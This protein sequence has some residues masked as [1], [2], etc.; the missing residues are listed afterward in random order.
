MLEVVITFIAGIV[1]FISP[2]VLPLVPAY[3]GYMGGRVTNTVS[4][5]ISV[6]GDGTAVAQPTHARFNT[7]LHGIAFVA[8]FTFIF[9]LLGVM[10]TAVLGQLGGQGTVIGIIGRLG[11]IVI[12]FF[13]FHFMGFVPKIFNWFRNQPDIINNPAFTILVALLLT[14]IFVWGFTGT[15]TP[16]MESVPAIPDWTIAVGLLL[17]VIT[18]MGMVAGGGFTEPQSFWNKAMNTVE[19]SIYADTRKDMTAS[20]NQGFG[21]SALMGVVFAAGWTP[22]IGPTLGAALTLAASNG[23]EVARGGLLLGA[24]SL[25]L[26][27]PFLLTAL[28]L[29]SAQGI[30]RR[31][32]RHMGIIELVSGAFLIFIGILVA[33]G[34][35]QTL[36]QRFA[37]EFAD[38]SYRIEECV[39]GFFEGDVHLNQVGGCL[40][41]SQSLESIRELNTGAEAPI[42]DTNIIES[43]PEIDFESLE[44]GLQIGD[45]APDFMTTMLDGVVVNLSDYRGQVVMLNFWHT[46]CGP[47]RIEMPEFQDAFVEYRDEGFTIV[48]VNRE[49]DAETILSFTDELDLTFPILMDE[50]GEIQAQ[51][52]VTGYPRTFILDENGIILDRNFGVLTPSQVEDWVNSALNDS[53]S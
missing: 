26:G 22:C 27:I 2:C 28:M 25:G 46:N 49:E 42:D 44:I 36:S 33:S 43:V 13:G 38:T 34:Q 10:S 9:V 17:S 50:S 20:T 5:Q 7:F 11:G 16:W 6:G 52:D 32:Q 51:Y 47:C 48:A 41:G 19:F 1:S 35:L 39:V 31:L 45:I 40:N 23:G 8:G 18:F 29:D 12:I 15:L 21:G 53:S 14:V 37:G 30:L 4:S 24:Y 3:I